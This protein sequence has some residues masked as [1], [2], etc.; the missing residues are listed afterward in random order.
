MFLE[1]VDEDIMVHSIKCGSKSSN[2]IDIALW[3]SID[4]KRNQYLRPRLDACADVSILPVSVYKLVFQDPDCKRLACSKHQYSQ[5]GWILYVLP[6]G[7]Q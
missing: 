5:I 4:H 7:Q 6:D 3:F 1:N 2:I